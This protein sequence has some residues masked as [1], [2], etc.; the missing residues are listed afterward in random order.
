MNRRVFTLLLV[1]LFLFC[2][3]AF[4]AVGIRNNGGILG[5]ATDININGATLDGSVAIA[6]NLCTSN[7]GVVVIPT[8][9]TELNVSY[10]TN[11]V[12][13]TT[14]TVT[15][16]S[17]TPNQ[18]LHIVAIDRVSGTLTIAPSLATGWSKATMDSDGEALTLLYVDS[19]TGWVILG[20]SGTTITATNA[21]Q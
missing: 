13:V 18:V 5:A 7:S 6:N 1:A 16:G 12:V 19:T 15:L 2:S 3:S 14:R 21:S 20:Y 9:T 4:A 8:S 11:K 17:G 10:K